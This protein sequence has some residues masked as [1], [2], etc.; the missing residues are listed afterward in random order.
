MTKENT[1]A[2]KGS[3]QKKVVGKAMG[4]S[5]IL[6]FFS[7]A[8]KD[9][10]TISRTTPENGVLKEAIKN[11][12][13]STPPSSRTNEQ[14]LGLLDG[15]A[16]T[17]AQKNPKVRKS[18]TPVSTLSTTSTFSPGSNIDT[19]GSITVKNTVVENAKVTM[20]TKHSDKENKLEQEEEEG[21]DDWVIGERRSKKKIKYIFSSDE[22]D[23]PDKAK[24]QT[25][26]EDDSMDG[27][28]IPNKEDKAAAEAEEE[29]ETKMISDFEV[30]EDN[31]TNEDQEM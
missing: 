28:Y 30:E 11:T 27:E 8:G 5:N 13:Q 25:Y 22:D 12:N 16:P 7:S 6:S 15:P 31:T 21:D 24:E 17:T 10:K 9:K 20:E 3:G 4:Q 19:P 23:E 2:K 1:S 14:I 18:F 26:H 29:E